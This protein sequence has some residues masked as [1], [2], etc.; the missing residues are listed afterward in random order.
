MVLKKTK[1]WIPW[2]YF[3]GLKFVYNRSFVWMVGHDYALGMTYDLQH[4]HL[5]VGVESRIHIQM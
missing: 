2:K 4:H 1:R 3:L 5:Y